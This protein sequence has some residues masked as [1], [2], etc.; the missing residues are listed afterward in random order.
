MFYHVV[1]L[2]FRE[3]V[4]QS[5]RKD[6]IAMLRN[7]ASLPEIREWHVGEQIKPDSRYDLCE[8]GVFDSQ[9]AFESFRKQPAHQA[10]VGIFPKIADW[11]VVDSVS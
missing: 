11:E 2:K 1:F 8:V 5:Q 3:D 6:A 9:E 7:L 10:V 4:P